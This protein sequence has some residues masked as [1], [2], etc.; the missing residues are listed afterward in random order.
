VNPDSL[1]AAYD[2]QG[3]NCDLTH[4]SK[5]LRRLGEPER[6]YPSVIVGGTNGK[7]SVCVT[8]ATILQASGYRVGLYTSPHLVDVR[9]R[10][11]VNGEPISLSDW[12]VTWDEF[13][14]GEEVGLSYFE[15]L[16]IMAFLYFRR[17]HVDIAVLEVGMG[18]RWDATNVAPALLSIITNVALDHQAYL[19]RTRTLI[20]REKGGIIKEKGICITGVRERPILNELTEICR[21]REA[22]LYR[23]GKDICVRRRPMGNSF[24]YVGRGGHY[25]N[26]SLAL[27]GPHQV[28]NAALAIA[29]TEELTLRGF[30]VGEEG[31][32]RGLMMVQWEGRME[33]LNG[34]PP[35]VLDG[36]HNVAGMR[37]FCRAIRE[38]FP[39]KRLI[40]LFGCLKDKDHRAMLRLLSPIAEELFLTTPPSPR[41][42]PAA[43]LASVV[44]GKVTVVD[45]PFAA[46][47]Q[48]CVAAGEGVWSWLPA[49]CIS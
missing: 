25:R 38:E 30:V 13:R 45:D 3:I 49:P 6:A 46:Y 37:A 44:P 9:E 22:Q 27:R 23:L 15:V 35:T 32:R 11:R 14:A 29:A 24:D 17:R 41:A 12:T 36:A 31:I 47:H 16:T 34:H 2:R 42:R 19:G 7:G 5:G 1:L 21:L 33:V 39:E 48:A 10:I 28:A 26:L 4:V 40:V 20:A 43:E 18:G 8:L